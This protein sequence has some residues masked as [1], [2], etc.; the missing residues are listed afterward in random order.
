[1]DAFFSYLTNITYY[2]IFAAV[3]G[4]IAP[5]GKYRKFVSLVMGFILLSLILVPLTNIGTRQDI[6]NWVLDFMPNQGTEISSETSYNLW[7]DT[8]IRSAFEA[9][10]TTQ[11]ELFLQQ[12]SIT[13]HTATFS[14]SDDFS[15]ITDIYV[16]VSGQQ[17]QERVP[18]IRI[19]PVRINR[20]EEVCPV[21]TSTKNLISQFY[22]LN[23]GHIHVTVT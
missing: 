19:E 10:L 8:Y 23:L 1:M 3:V 14:F 6:S 20:E 4:L 9:Q 15:A 2:L 17:I 21:A 12:N 5:V 13:L 18:F 7:R 11:L 16:T 22:N